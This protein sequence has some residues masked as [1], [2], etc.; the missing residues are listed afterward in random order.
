LADKPQVVVLTKKDLAKPE[1]LENTREAFRE[2]GIEPL[3]ISAMKGE[4]L[5]NLKEVF[6]LEL[7][8]HQQDLL[9][10]GECQPDE[11]EED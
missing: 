3:T 2:R 11:P 10:P 9:E 8:K 6:R 5:S 7:E 4:G 1:D